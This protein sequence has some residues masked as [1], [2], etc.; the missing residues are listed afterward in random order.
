[1]EI[2][3]I[4]KYFERLFVQYSVFM[5]VLVHRRSKLLNSFEEKNDGTTA[6]IGGATAGAGMC[7]SYGADG[8]FL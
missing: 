4:T 8:M 7:C 3:R 1:M 6:K 2:K 5:D